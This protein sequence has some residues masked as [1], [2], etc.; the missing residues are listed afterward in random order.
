MAMQ[1]FK[2]PFAAISDRRKIVSG[3]S[4]TLVWK[5]ICWVMKQRPGRPMLSGKTKSK[6]HM[7]KSSAP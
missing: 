6:L 3:R 7:W 2:S 1:P 4:D 5:R